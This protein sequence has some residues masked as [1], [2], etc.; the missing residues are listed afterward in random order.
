MKYFKCEFSDCDYIH[1]DTP[2]KIA[3]SNDVKPQGCIDV[4]KFGD[5]QE[6][7]KEEFLKE[8]E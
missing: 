7:T 1:D 3:S 4:L 8:I 2:C 6:I 5:W